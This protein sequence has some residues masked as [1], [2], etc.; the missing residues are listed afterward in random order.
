M[1]DTGRGTQQEHAL[2]LRLFD[3]LLLAGAGFAGLGLG[4]IV[5]AYTYEVIARYLF[6][7]PT[8]WSSEL[9]AYLLCIMTFTMMPYV[10]A[11]RAHVAVTIFLD[12]LN[13]RNKAVAE[14]MIWIAGFI[15]CAAMTWFAGGE[16][17]RQF[18]RNIQMMAAQPIPKWWIS[19]WIVLGFALSALAFLRLAIAGPMPT[20]LDEGE[21]KSETL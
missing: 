8:W 19:V 3:V 12:Y 9:V 6:N 13:P 10:T 14:R 4:L 2:V 16:T 17:L 7:A 18:T 11:T 20:V 5:S 15:A 21:P 1:E